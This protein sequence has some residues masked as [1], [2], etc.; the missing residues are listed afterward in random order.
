VFNQKYVK[1]YSTIAGEICQD[2]YITLKGMES[3]TRIARSTVSRNLIEMYTERCLFGPWLSLNPH[4]N[5]SQ[6]VYVM[7][8]SDPQY[9]FEG[10]KEFPYVRYHAFTFGEWNTI[11]ITE[12]L[13]DLSVLKGFQ[14]AIVRRE[15]GFTY[16][17]PVTYTTWEECWKRV[18]E[19]VETMTLRGYTGRERPVMC[20]DE[21]EWALY[22]AFKRNVRA[23]VLP[24]RRKLDVRHEYYAPW[25]DDVLNH[26]RIHTEFYPRPVDRYT[27]HCLLVRTRYGKSVE[28]V[29]SLFPTTPVCVEMADWILISVKMTS[30]DT[31]RLIKMMYD[32]KDRGVIEDVKH[33]VIFKDHRL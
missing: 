17:P 8:F 15:K 4:E 32:M 6:Y 9:M 21:T 10:L 27:N 22:D 23:K 16:T 18:D 33:A 19:M 2:P 5:Y 11:V 14:S 7:N 29:F 20:W 12:R 28:E 25:R 30:H 26:C 3:R 24:I 13:L 1:R 31:G